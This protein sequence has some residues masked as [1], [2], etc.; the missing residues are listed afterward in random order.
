MRLIY[1]LLL[2]VAVNCAAQKK[3][4]PPKSSKP[5]AIEKGEINFPTASGQCVYNGYMNSNVTTRVDCQNPKEPL[6]IVNNA[7]RERI[8][9]L[10]SD[11]SLVIK[12]TLATI[13]ELIKHIYVQ[14]HALGSA[15]KELEASYSKNRKMVNAYNNMID[16][17]KKAWKELMDKLTVKK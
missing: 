17:Q 1:F 3:S 16:T 13:K 7:N 12:D 8:A 15:Y 11:S 2:L 4:T 10:N 6:L 14:E 5:T 9:Y